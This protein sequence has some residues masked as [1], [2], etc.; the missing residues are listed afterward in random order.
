[1]QDGLLFLIQLRI[2]TDNRTKIKGKDPRT[3]ILGEVAGND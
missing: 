1:M 2:F 3:A